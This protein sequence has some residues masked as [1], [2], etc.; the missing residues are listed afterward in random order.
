MRTSPG[1]PQELQ[2][3]SSLKTQQEPGGQGTFTIT[4]NRPSTVYQ[5]KLRE[6]MNNH[7][8][9][10]TLPIQR[11]TPKG[12][13]RFR[14]IA[15]AMGAK[16]GVDT[17]GLVATHNSSF[18]GKLNAEATIQGNKIHFAPGMDNDHN[19]KHEVAHAIDNTLKGT[20]KGDKV[21]NG[22]KVDTTR[23]KIVERMAKDDVRS[24]IVP[25]RA[26]TGKGDKSYPIQRKPLNTWEERTE[27]NIAYE[28]DFIS[29]LYGNSPTT[30]ADRMLMSSNKVFQ[31]GKEPATDEQVEIMGSA[32]YLRKRKHDWREELEKRKNGSYAEQLQPWE[33][34]QQEVEELTKPHS[35]SEPPWYLDLMNGYFSKSDAH[36]DL[37]TKARDAYKFPKKDDPQQILGMTYHRDTHLSENKKVDALKELTQ[38]GPGC[39]YMYKDL[40]GREFH[41][42]TDQEDEDE[43][44]EEDNDFYSQWEM[45]GR[46]IYSKGIPF[47]VE[48]QEYIFCE[49]D[50]SLLISKVGPENENITIDNYNFNSVR[51]FSL[52]VYNAIVL[53]NIAV[54]HYGEKDMPVIRNRDDNYQPGLD[55]TTLGEIRARTQS[56]DHLEYLLGPHQNGL[57]IREL[58]WP[59]F[60]SFHRRFGGDILF[61]E[62]FQP[63]QEPSGYTNLIPPGKDVNTKDPYWYYDLQRDSPGRFVA[64]RSNSTLNYIQTVTLLWSMGKITIQEAMDVIAFIVA[65]MV[66]TG[67]HSMP[68]CMMT[69]IRVA[70]RVEP[71]ANTKLNLQKPEQV[72][73]TWLI[74]VD[75]ITRKDMLQNTHDALVNL[76][77]KEHKDYKLLK[78]LTALGK[79]IR[80]D[81]MPA[82]DNVE[83]WEVDPNL[84][85]R[86]VH[87]ALGIPRSIRGLV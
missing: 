51:F 24:S 46:V 25:R 6:T 33:H 18:P 54:G 87:D 5:R 10:H 13:S 79:A 59:I 26:V 34:F 29:L 74:L 16:H 83:G 12:S 63:F 72:L 1:R 43:V 75:D 49:D 61:K 21:V 66:V 40:N 3:T 73:H 76:I 45:A 77:S 56:V 15:T 85:N 69:V 39:I 30:L 58:G 9:G 4:D 71:W 78:V 62:A 22:Q 86:E 32:S 70:D 38:L 41:V 47:L 81:D 11:N 7:T 67:N 52:A 23:E 28:M 20:P 50:R 48:N 44:Y 84:T 14:Q 65:D 42:L 60:V 17:S 80:G 82:D 64:G 53:P 35:E 55:D 68:E 36:S 31:Y 2:N 37:I 19:I 27:K 57:N 8:A